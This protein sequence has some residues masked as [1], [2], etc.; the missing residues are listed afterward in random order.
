M[1]TMV[2]RKH[3]YREPAYKYEQHDHR[4]RNTKYIEKHGNNAGMHKIIDEY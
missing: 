3:A 4:I 2:Q 1:L